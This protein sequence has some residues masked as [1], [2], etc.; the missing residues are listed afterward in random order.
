M[1]DFDSARSIVLKCAVANL[2]T[3]RI[4]LQRSVGRVLAEQVT[5]PID[6]PTWDYSAMDGYALSSSDLTHQMTL[7]VAGECRTG[8]AQPAFIP[9]TCLRIFTGATIPAGVDS[10]VMQEEV[11]RSSNMA[12]F[13][14]VPAVGAHIRRRGEDLAIGDL[15]IERGVRLSP[16]HMGLL[17]SVERSEVLV[18]RRPRVTILCT[19]DELRPP[20]YLLAAGTLAESNSASL[21]ALVHAVG[22]EA[23][24]GPIIRDERSV[25]RDEIER[26]ARSCDV[27]VTVGGVSVGDHDVVRPVLDEMGAEILFHKVRIK[28]GKPVLLAK[29]KDTFIVGL[30]GNPASAQVTFALFAAPLIRSLAGDT[31][32]V[33][34]FRSV[35]L[36]ESYRQ[37]PGRKCFV[38]AHLTHEGVRVLSN[39]S[40]GAS[41]SIAWSNALVIFDEDVQE[42]PAGDA[43]S[44]LALSDL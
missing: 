21:A 3:E 43:V 31:Q 16:F 9:G 20:G 28:P 34:D 35:P 39:Q 5:S 33:P 42:V 12:T 41:T 23:H 1:I 19:G 2:P 11:T 8:H 29:W 26:Q 6:L 22:G 4:V 7:P 25:L 17:A 36:L 27:I 30:P 37:G 13:S 18:S 38:R 32:P 44:V 15:V 14:N 24:L 40:S 10:V